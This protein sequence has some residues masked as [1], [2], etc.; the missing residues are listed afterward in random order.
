MNENDSTGGDAGTEIDLAS[1]I[2]AFESRNFSQALRLLGP[3]AEAG[4]GDAQYRLAIMYQNGL[5]VVR[6]EETAARWMRSAAFQG[7]ALAEHGLGCMYLDGDCVRR[8]SA[9]AAVWLARAAA[10]GLEGS[11]LLLDMIRENGA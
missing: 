10:Q 2:A 5:G 3:L 6:S 4:D 11:K 1:G 8:D 7:M 9:Q